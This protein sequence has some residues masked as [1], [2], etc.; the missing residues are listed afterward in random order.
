M[1]TLTLETQEMI[2]P[3]MAIQL[4]KE[5]NH[6][7]IHQQQHSRD[8]L[9]QVD[10]TKHGQWPFATILSCIDSRVSSELIFDQGIGDI[11]AIRV[12]GNH[13]NKDV[14]GS[15]E[16]A[17]HVAKSKL[18]V[19][20]GHTNCG[21][22]KGSLDFHKKIKGNGITNLEHLLGKFEDSVERIKTHDEERCSSNHDLLQK[23]TIENVEHTI[24]KIRERSPILAEM[25]QQNAI[26][27][28]GAIYDVET[29]VVSWL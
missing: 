14:L 9:A 23:L 16:Y 29:G 8:L 1:K 15:M 5:G 6:R 19:V 27:I 2:T 25:E 11:F 26:Q 28:V 7:F 20:L 10:A 22:M 17:C 13:I 21:A 12:A 3:T 24:R 18:V 4:L